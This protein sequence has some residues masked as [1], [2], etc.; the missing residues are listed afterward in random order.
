M[1]NPRSPLRPD[2]LALD[3]HIN[4]DLG[5]PISGTAALLLSDRGKPGYVVGMTNEESDL[6]ILQ[7]Q[8]MKKTGFLIERD[9]SIPTLL[10][11]EIS[12]IA[13]IAGARRIIMPYEIEGLTTLSWQ[14]YPYSLVSSRLGL[15]RS[16]EEK[17]LVKYL[18]RPGQ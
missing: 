14:T 4:P 3:L 16:T 10:T 17:A 13:R 5:I 7:M 9:L 8:G 18:I 12:F 2:S 6:V 11:A 15:E 1:R